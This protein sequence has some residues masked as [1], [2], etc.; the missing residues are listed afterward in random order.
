M[1]SKYPDDGFAPIEDVPEPLGPRRQKRERKDTG[2]CLKGC[3]IAV[4]VVII[5]GAI[6]LYACER[7]V[8]EAFTDDPQEVEAM[9]QRIAEY[10]LPEGFSPQGAV[11]FPML[12][13]VA[14]FARK[15]EDG[16][17]QA[18]LALGRLEIELDER[19]LLENMGRATGQETGD[20]EVHSEPCTVGER[21]AL[22]LDATTLVD[23]EQVDAVRLRWRAVVIPLDEG[24][25]VG[26][27]VDQQPRFAEAEA[28][29]FLQS[30]RSREP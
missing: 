7:L 24:A 29:I 30:L 9:A 14:F 10:T 5:L 20:M 19:E 17:G 1:S 12:G 28:E 3:L 18:M 23:G 11:D 4:V 13:R 8:T 15:A 16:P 6:S 25:L 2:G 27:A 21:Q 26:A 22:C